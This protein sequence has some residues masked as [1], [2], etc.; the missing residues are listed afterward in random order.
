LRGE[1]G[2][3]GDTN[4][5]EANQAK[6]AQIPAQNTSDKSDIAIKDAPVPSQRSGSPF[7]TSRS[8]DCRSPTE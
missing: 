1:T 2:E 4:T 3:L 6:A 7:S 5:V 8:A